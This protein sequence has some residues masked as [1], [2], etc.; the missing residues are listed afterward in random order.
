[1][2]R[3]LT[4]HKVNACNSNIDV[5]V[6]DQPGA[7]NA[8]REYTVTVHHEDGNQDIEINF[9]NGPIAEVGTNGLTHEVLLAIVE[10][11]LLGFQ[12]GAYACRENALALTHI[13]EAIMWLNKRTAD[14]FERGVE[15]THV[16]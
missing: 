4:S 11:R 7:G 9:Q 15:G 5:R 16:I 3:L 6:L 1:M 2:P 12:S 14:R 13:Q 10:D 8:C